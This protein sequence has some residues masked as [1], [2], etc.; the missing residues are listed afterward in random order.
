MKLRKPALVPRLQPGN[1]LSQEAPASCWRC[2]VRAPQPRGKK[3][4]PVFRLR[5]QGTGG[6]SLRDMGIPRQE[7]GNERVFLSGRALYLTTV[8]RCPGLVG[9]TTL[10]FASQ[11]MP[12]PVGAVMN[13]TASWTAVV[14]YRFCRQTHAR[15]SF[16]HP[17]CDSA[18]PTIAS[19]IPYESGRGLP[20]SKTLSR[21]PS[22]WPLRYFLLTA[23]RTLRCY[24][25]LV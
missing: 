25:L 12:K 4:L 2:A 10:S 17:L 3:D 13:A 15:A 22:S 8:R 9:C 23:V 7:L 16:A 6:W 14:L 5:M 1:A 24:G 18:F 19:P 11:V 20:H 21:P